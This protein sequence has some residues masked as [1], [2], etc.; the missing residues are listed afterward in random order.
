MQH[1]KLTVV[2][3]NVEASPTR[4]WIFIK[5]RMIFF[6]IL[7]LWLFRPQNGARSGGFENAIHMYCRFR[8]EGQKGG[9]RIRSCHTSK[10]RHLAELPRNHLTTP[11]TCKSLHG[12]GFYTAEVRFL[13]LA[14]ENLT[15]IFA[16]KFS[17]S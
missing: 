4:I 14:A 16:F 13:T 1:L 10:W 15:S 3:K 5:K 2:L 17:H 7:A 9:F 6:A 11:L 12:Q 8:V